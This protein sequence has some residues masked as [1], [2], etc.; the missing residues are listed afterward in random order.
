MTA[1]PFGA[2]SFGM[3]IVGG[4][5]L[6]TTGRVFFVD[7]TA[8]AKGDDANHGA[9]PTTPFATI[10]FAIGQ[11]AANRGDTI[12]VLPGHAESLIAASGINCDV[13]G[14]RIRGL[15]D[16]RSRPTI[17]FT[18][19]V[20]ASLD[21]NAANVIFENF[22]L[23]L[24]G[25]TALVGPINFAAADTIFQDNE[26]ITAT[27]SNK[28]QNV[29]TC[30]SNGNRVH[31]LSNY[32][33]GLAGQAHSNSVLL[34]S[35]NDG[36]EF[37]YNRVEVAITTSGLIADAGIA[38]NLFIHHNYFLNLSATPARIMIF[39]SATT[40]V[41]SYN[42]LAHQD[43]PSEV[44]L[45]TTGG[46]LA[47]I[48][49]YGYDTSSGSIVNKLG[50]LV[51][52]VGASLSTN[53]S[54]IDEIIG[55][56]MSYNRTNYL[57]IAV[58]LTSVTWNTVAA[59]E[60]LTVTG[61]VRVKILPLCDGSVTSGGAISFTLG[62]QTTTNAF[63]TATD[64]TT[65]DV[66]MFWLSATPAK[67]FATTSVIDRVVSDDDIGYTIATNAAT[68]GSLTFHVW[69]EPLDSF[70]AVAAGAGGVL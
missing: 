51:P 35:T 25:I 62:T 55:A 42:T 20:A 23:D 36:L 2:S 66:D 40:G 15:S 52:P 6:M 56:Q 10:D 54:L 22:I 61:C 7:S 49:N 32:I 38:T 16:G 18:T 45:D 46:T 8:A 64:G 68:G 3:P 50:V 44:I 19:S 43:V 70:G 12:L 27:G 63:I 4:G 21:F 24:S 41:V 48:E 33:H 69:W 59:H 9:A 57:A 28:A 60:I 5:A 65:I 26:L 30:T 31:I 39:G 47:F 37:A 13:A 1:F 17:T 11:C 14:I 53:R 58:D 29:M 67:Q 34:L